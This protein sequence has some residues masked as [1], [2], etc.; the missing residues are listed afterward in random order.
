MAHCRTSLSLFSIEQQERDF[1]S[2]K[3]DHVAPLFKNFQWFPIT[4]R[5]N[6]SVLIAYKLLLGLTSRFLCVFSFPVILLIAYCT[7]ATMVPLLFLK[8]AEHTRVS[9][10]LPLL[11]LTPKCSSST[12]LYDRLTNSCHWFLFIHILH[13]LKEYV[14]CLY[15]HSC[16]FPPKT[17]SISVYP[18]TWL[19]FPLYHLL[20]PNIL[21]YFII[22]PSPY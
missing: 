6:F 5:I 9:G 16:F 8:Y 11:S 7:L 12:Y 1:L 13:I 17:Q 18:I 14:F 21:L 22:C 2:G 20:L 19:Y 10:H 4:L 3:S 15:F